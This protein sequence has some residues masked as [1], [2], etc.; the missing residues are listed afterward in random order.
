ML[1]KK[2]WKVAKNNI[3]I[4]ELKE[5]LNFSETFLRLLAVR[6]F[7][8]STKIKALLYDGIEKLDDPRKIP[9]IEKGA[10]RIIRAIKMAQKIRI[11]GDYDVDGITA[12]AMLYDY[13]K[14]QG[15]CTDYYLP[16]RLEEG[17]GLNQK[18]ILKAKNDGVDI[19]IT[20]DC[21]ITGVKE[22]SY[23]KGLGME[24]IITDH[25]Q[26]PDILPDTEIIINPKLS[27]E[28]KPWYHLA[29]VGV[30]LKLIQ[31]ISK[32]NDNRDFDSYY[33]F[34]AA[35]GTISDIVPLSKENRIIVKEG[36]KVINNI[37]AKGIKALMSVS[38]ASD[39]EIGSAEV[40]YQLAPRINA[41]GRLGK[42]DV[43]VE[44]LL[45][46]DEEWANQTAIYFENQNRNRKIIENKIME[47][48]EKIIEEQFDHEKDKMIVIAEEKWHQG[49]VGIIASR[50]VEKYNRPSIVISL[51]N[52]LGKG[53]GR[54]I[55]AFNL[56]KALEKHS[57]LL[58]SYGG[59]SAAAG[60]SIKAEKICELKEKL[61]CDLNN[62]LTEKDFAPVLNADL[63]IEAE[64]LDTALVQEI[65]LLAPFGY[66][67]PYPILVLRSKKITD[68]KR[69]GAQ[70]NHLKLRI[71]SGASCFDAIAFKKGDYVQEIFSE[72]KYDIAITP[73]INSYYGKKRLQLVVADIKKAQ[74]ADD[75]F[76][77]LTFMERLFLEGNVWLEDNLY[78]DLID[79]NE[80][81]TKLVGVTFDNR[82]K[83]I[84]EIKE[85][86]QVELIREVQ[87]KYDHNAI[88]VYWQGQ[89]VGYLNSRLA[90]AL[91][92]CLDKKEIYEA[93]V[94]KITGQTINSL[95]VNIQVIKKSHT[96]N[97]EMIKSQREKYRL[98]DP[99]DLFEKIKL[100]VIGADN[101]YD[102][103]IEAMENLKSNKNTLAIFATGRGKTAIFQSMAAYFALYCRKM[104][105]IIYPLR[106]LVNDQLHRMSRQLGELGI[107]VEA[108]NGSMNKEERQGFF[109]RMFEG[110]IDIVL[111]TPEFLSFH[112]EKFV[113]IAEKIGFFV[114][115]EAHHL[116]RGKRSGYRKLENSWK[117]LG[118]P[119]SLA[120]TATADTETAKRITD[121]LKSQTTIVEKHIR[122][123]IRIQ[124][125][126]N[127]RDKLAYLLD[128]ISSGEKTVIY[129]NSR[130][131]AY[132]I[133]RDIRRYYPPLYEQTAFYHGGLCSEHRKTLEDM[134]RKSEILIMVSTSAFGEG[135]DIPDIKHVILYHMS[136]SR[137]EFNQLAG[138]AGRNNEEAF[139]HIIFGEKDKKLN[140]MILEENSPN[141]E[142]LGKL[143]C[144]LR[145]KKA[146]QPLL[147]TNNEIKEEL[148][149]AGA[150]KFNE[151]SVSS[152]LGILEELGLIR[153]E[154]ESNKRHIYL[155]PPPS[156]KLDLKDSVRYIEGLDEIEEFTSFSE[157]IFK[158]NAEEMLS[159]I[160][161]P[162]FPL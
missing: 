9:G 128:I 18:A 86:D 29:G 97:N 93:Y 125:K 31:E 146:V 129:V 94:S 49:V 118:E 130:K 113:C 64:E 115:D 21:G 43:A 143:Y 50:L 104:S 22:V 144:C 140:K 116:A 108:I 139:I 26:P 92:N 122:N 127:T 38:G 136:F 55:P 137:A 154:V 24:I 25:H 5:N 87:N 44:M 59:H 42:A 161:R 142:V 10:Q 120:V 51:E 85:K 35:L 110:N 48:A 13:L 155:L 53:S 153:R 151:Q 162:I 73:E 89:S 133:A 45:T 79:K 119:L 103:Q 56:Y 112:I 41:C 98:L 99:D 148:N 34:L 11:Y 62:E 123:N 91:T 152:G 100:A 75:P 90:A 134:F 121:I 52:G 61:N 81:Y 71:S 3:Q 96:E 54:S 68:C 1:E 117:A 30:A 131:Q 60:I 65:A 157:E 135:V 8:T 77:P 160:N 19:I 39:K 106:S 95:G 126:R 12:T 67:N 80:F 36:L 63:E 6:G 105:L 40:S 58:I 114:V 88:G 69:V 101:Y 37:P 156:G 27:D 149:K 20:V 102:K 70:G 14:R 28:K 66:H 2:I 109:T 16:E 47:R 76:V 158:E 147:L 138:R 145:D 150:L 107:I 15:A 4:E 124:D 17:Y 78:R 141:R 33:L 83:I 84:A 72:E 111:T 74:E 82:Q 23:A 7:L 57:D 159:R 46:N 132:I 32:I